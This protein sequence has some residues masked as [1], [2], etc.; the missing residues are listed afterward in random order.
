MPLFPVELWYQL[1]HLLTRAVLL[2]VKLPFIIDFEFFEASLNSD[3]SKSDV[4]S[5]ITAIIE[6]S[7]D[8]LRDLY[9][10]LNKERY[11]WTEY[12]LDSKLK[13]LYHDLE[14]VRLYGDSQGSESELSPVSV[15]LMYS[16]SIKQGLNSFANG[17]RSGMNIA[18]FTTEEAHKLIFHI[19]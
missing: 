14:A 13:F 7:T 9:I 3:K 12:T 4:L 19:E 1:G 17:I 15:D 18:D 10:L 8:L 5:E 6:K 16:E 11:L 2:R